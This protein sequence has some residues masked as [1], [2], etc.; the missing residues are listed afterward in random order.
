MG[1][2]KTVKTPATG[3]IPGRG[4]SY[5]KVEC[6]S[7][8]AWISWTFSLDRDPNHSSA[9]KAKSTGY[10]A[11]I[12]QLWCCVQYR[13][14]LTSPI[15]FINQD[16]SSPLQ[17]LIPG[18]VTNISLLYH[19]ISSDCDVDTASSF[20]CGQA[21][22]ELLLRRV[23]K[24]QRGDDHSLSSEAML[25]HQW[26]QCFDGAAPVNSLPQTVWRSR[27]T[28]S[29]S[30]LF[31]QC[32]LNLAT[33]QKKLKLKSRIGFYLYSAFVRGFVSELTHFGQF[34]HY[35]VKHISSQTRSEL[36]MDGVIASNIYSIMSVMDSSSF[37]F[38][39]T[40]PFHQQKRATEAEDNQLRTDM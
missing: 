12:F 5:V 23:K 36:K 24:A 32:L 10:Q 4:P 15:T 9:S 13:G 38:P 14:I 8:A 29:T 40:H 3:S 20:P 2:V 31:L 6:L 17:C 19:F 11:V 37:P 21:C 39:W 22:R 18:R 27:W 25:R 26:G 33:F 34:L 1:V 7:H 35:S 16:S 30:G 28:V